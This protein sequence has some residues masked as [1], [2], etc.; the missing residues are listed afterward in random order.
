MIEEDKSKKV[1]S[2]AIPHQQQQQKQLRSLKNWR[3]KTFSISTK[4][5]HR[6]NH[7]HDPTSPCWGPVNLHLHTN[8]HTL[9]IKHKYTHALFHTHKHKYTHSFDIRL[10]RKYINNWTNSKNLCFKYSYFPNKQK[11]LFLSLGHGI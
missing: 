1:Q 6:V 3:K 2:Q 4:R 8:T 10:L 11:V 5:T 9:S 7:S